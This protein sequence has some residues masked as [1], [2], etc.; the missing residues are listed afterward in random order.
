MPLPPVREVERHR[1]HRPAQVVPRRFRDT[2]GVHH[3]P[4]RAGPEVAKKPGQS[5]ASGRTPPPPFAEGLR[6]HLAGH[7]APERQVALMVTIPECHR[8]RAEEPG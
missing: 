5:T 7:H 3:A 1:R 8:V 2:R 6:H 4:P